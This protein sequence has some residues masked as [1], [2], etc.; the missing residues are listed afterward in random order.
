MKQR[1]ESFVGYIAENWKIKK[2]THRYFAG[3]HECIDIDN[4]ICTKEALEKCGPNRKKVKVTIEEIDNEN[5]N[6]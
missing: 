4:N 6:T 2:Y 1:K 5:P 3:F